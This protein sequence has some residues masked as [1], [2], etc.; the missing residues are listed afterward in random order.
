MNLADSDNIVNMSTATEK[1]A[2][3]IITHRGAFKWM[4]VSEIPITS[5]ARKGVAIMRELKKDSHE[6]IA[7]IVIDQQAPAALSIYTSRGKRFDVSP[8]DHALSQRYS[9]G[10]FIID[11]DTDG[12]PT[13]IKLYDETKV[14][15]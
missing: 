9:N 8:K 11:T 3:A 2:L 12:Q 5:R 13:T 1:Q 14:E 6:I 10:S 7:T 15:N 4:P